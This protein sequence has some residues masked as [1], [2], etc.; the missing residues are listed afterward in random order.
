LMAA[1]V[2]VGRA[3]GLAGFQADVLSTNKPMLTL[4]TRTGLDITSRMDA[5]VTRVTAV[6]PRDIT[7]TPTPGL[8]RS[9]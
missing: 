1:M 3:R 2:E 4:M 6:F 7:P 5:G 9:V 8:Q